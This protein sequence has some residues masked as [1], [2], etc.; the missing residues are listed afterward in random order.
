MDTLFMA[1]LIGGI[2]YAVVSVIFGD[3]LSQA[4]DGVLDFLSIDGPAFLQP[5]TL[6]GGITVFG[7][8]GLLMSKYSGLSG[9]LVLLFAFLIAVVA[10][11]A[12]F[13]LYVKP[14]E[15][16]ENSI[17][18]SIRSLEGSL[19]EVIVP[20]PESGY[21]EVLVKVGAGFTNQI[22][23]S[24]DKRTIPAGARIVVV[25]VVDGVLQVSEVN[26]SI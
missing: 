25:E 4:L 8:A 26:L 9:A 16:S 19:G 1:C 22:A 3:W 17:A 12:V 24:F 14:M 20:I 6:V 5:M 23:S 13:F 2:L 15:N 18:F 10:S 21:G 7:G 11:I